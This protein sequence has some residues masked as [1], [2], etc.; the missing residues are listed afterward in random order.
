MQL[1]PHQV[2]PKMELSSL[3]RVHK[4]HS[5]SLIGSG[6]S[7]LQTAGLPESRGAPPR[8]QEVRKVSLVE[9]LGP[10]LEQNTTQQ[11]LQQGQVPQETVGAS[12]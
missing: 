7:S 12:C 10:D 8:G 6:H 5:H 9:S 1:I 3:P 11:V 4:C 2:M